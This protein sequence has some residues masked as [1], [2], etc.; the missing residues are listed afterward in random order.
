[1]KE[2]MQE[3]YKQF[4]LIQTILNYPDMYADNYYTQLSIAT[5][6]AYFTMNAGMCNDTAVCEN[7]MDHRNFVHKAMEILSVLEVDEKDAEKYGMLFAEYAMR[8]NAIVERI[9]TILSS[10]EGSRIRYDIPL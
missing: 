2:I 3:A 1:M 7:C 8:V 6:E 10:R 5:E 4:Q 9:K